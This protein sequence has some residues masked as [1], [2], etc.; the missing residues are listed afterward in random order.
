[1]DVLGELVEVVPLDELDEPSVRPR[2]SVTFDDAYQGALAIGV[3]EIVKRGMPVTIFVAPGRLD[4]Q[5]FWWDS[6]AN[7]QGT[8]DEEMRRVALT[9]FRGI[10]TQVRA[11]IAAAGLSSCNCLPDYARTAT[12][13]ELQAALALPGVTVGSHSWSHPNLTSLNQSDL[14][15]ELETSYNWLKKQFGLKMIPWLAY[16]YGLHSSATARAAAAVGYSAA[17]AISGGWHSPAE[18]S[19]FARPRLNVPA[20][21]SVAGF[22][23]RLLGTFTS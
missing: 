21:V 12:E 1:L 16:P 8:F 4:R 13:K 9:K 2:A 19:R 22:K 20:G 11:W 15:H 17:L 5:S 18:S 14:L 10:D 23:A 3:P 7:L 6:I